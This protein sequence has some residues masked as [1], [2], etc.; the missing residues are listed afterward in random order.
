MFERLELE[1]W[2]FDAE[3]LALAQRL[4][5]RVAEVGIE[6]ADRPNSRPSIRDV[7]IPAVG[8]LRAAR[9]NVRRVTPQSR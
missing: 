9:A 2:V 6:W 8:E 3:A 7:L 5:Y 1:G 4:G